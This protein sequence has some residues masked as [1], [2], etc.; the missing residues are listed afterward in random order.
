MT[1]HDYLPRPKCPHCGYEMN[2]AHELRLSDG[3]TETI[4]CGECDK[5]FRVTFH[6]SV[7]YSTSNEGKR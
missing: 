3:E 2:D 7:S 6:M 5:P 4:D 1:E